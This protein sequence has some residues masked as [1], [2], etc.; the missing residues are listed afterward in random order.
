MYQAFPKLL[1]C[2]PFGSFILENSRDA[3]LP[4]GYKLFRLKVRVSNIGACS[5]TQ[6]N[7]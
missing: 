7:T 6:S 2:A 3:F 1:D 4:V 5:D